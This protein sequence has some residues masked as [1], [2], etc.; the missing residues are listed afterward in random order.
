MAG[1]QL[2]A[3]IILNME[4]NVSSKSRQFSNSIDAMAKKNS[5]SFKVLKNNIASFSNTLD[6]VGT[7]SIL[8]M[9]AAA[10]GFNRTFIKTAAMFERYQLQA[11][12][13]FG[14]P[15]GGK[16]AMA[17]AKQNA[18][19]TVLSLEQVMD[20]M[21]TMKGFGM[22]PM[23]GKLKIMEDVSAQHGWTYDKLSGAMMQ[24]DQMYAKG[25]IGMDDAKLLMGY[26]V[27]VYKEIA[28]AL[29]V[30]IEKVMAAGSSKKGLGLKFLEIFFKQLGIE[31]DGAS[32]NAMNKWDGLISNLGDS[33]QQFQQ[34]VMNRG[35]FDKLKNRVRQ[36]KS[37]VEDKDKANAAAHSTAETFDY[38][39]DAA[40]GA[41]EGLWA[42]I[43]GIGTGIKYAADKAGEVH[44]YFFGARKETEG[45]DKNVNK[46]ITDMKILAE[47][48]AGMYIANKAFRMAKPVVKGSWKLGK[49]VF[50]PFAWVWKKVFGKNKPEV[51]E[52][53][54][55]PGSNLPKAAQVQ[56]VFVTNWPRGGFGNNGG[57]D[58]FG[59]N[60][61]NN[62]NKKNRQKKGPGKGRN[63]SSRIVN[64]G[65]EILQ[66]VEKAGGKG[67][68]NKIKSIGNPKKLW[69]S[70]KSIGS[71]AKGLGSK[72][73]WIS[74][75]ITAANVASDDNNTQRG[76]DIGNEVGY[77]IGGT[78][79]SLTDEV[80]GPFGTIV[81]AQI[82]Q[83]IGDKLGAMVGSWFDDEKDKKDT[84]SAQ[85]DLKG[86][87]DINI[88]LP[89]GASVGSSYSSFGGMNPFNLMTGGYI[90]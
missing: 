55:K 90:P 51:G 82:G 43:K 35:P 48:L 49:G 60:D 19:E 73:P 12:S 6:K 3:S 87:I 14:G 25:K 34:N 77:W 50:K 2:K 15:E 52:E 65:E 17:W 5:K 47:V 81:G 84:A 44:D 71:G 64:A 62:K 22:N 45:V 36:I 27:N 70:I 80:T 13:L 69:G 10:Y 7:R 57:S 79:G 41:A 24:I 78:L 26:G 33:W 63:R 37:F 56:R 66:D 42:V 8:G 11:N 61:R 20:L 83:T 58:D 38:S 1:K 54:Q 4:G 76:A 67:L 32:K 89:E 30:P 21:T 46:T 31:S 86:K 74:A 85:Q 28:T 68:W 88:N 29:N 40:T 59:G 75:A 39:I 53:Y 23:D 72:L 16:Q 9:T 18:K